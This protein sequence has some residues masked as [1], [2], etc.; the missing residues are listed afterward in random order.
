M[1][2]AT[3]T[4]R[5]GRAWSRRLL[6]LGAVLLGTAAA[7]AIYAWWP[8][9]SYR[10]G[11]VRQDY[12]YPSRFARDAGARPVSNTPPAGRRLVIPRIGVDLPVLDGDVE[13]AL[14]RGVYRYPESGLPGEPTNMAVAGHRVAG[15]F[16]LL[17]LLKRGD[18]VMLYWDGV[19]YCYRVS[20]KI[21][22]DASDT[23]I[24]APGDGERLTLYTCVPRYLGDR[25]TVVVALPVRS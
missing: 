3:E 20:T 17:H 9:A 4:H 19:E 13:K 18:E 6:I 11:L 1:C 14:E 16:A 5:G 8:D 22:V 24:L 23:S 10:L 12:P 15:R 21:E 25:R 2:R 7:L